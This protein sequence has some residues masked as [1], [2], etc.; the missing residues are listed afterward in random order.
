MGRK[1]HALETFPC[2]GGVRESQQLASLALLFLH[3]YTEHRNIRAYGEVYGKEQEGVAA[4]WHVPR[5]ERRTNAP[6]SP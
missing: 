3:K 4:A 1:F 6:V 2:V 5:C